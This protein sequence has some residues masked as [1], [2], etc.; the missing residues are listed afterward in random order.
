MEAPAVLCAPQT[1]SQHPEEDWE[2]TGHILKMW[3]GP[4]AS[5]ATAELP[6]GNLSHSTIA[7]RSQPLDKEP[8][9][10]WC[11]A[12]IEVNQE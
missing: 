8:S 11:C 7:F 9:F 2:I 1:P 4:S 10:A 5:T 3:H 12:C 6:A